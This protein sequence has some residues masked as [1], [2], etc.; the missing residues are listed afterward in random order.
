VA[1]EMVGK[2]N[3]GDWRQC[4]IVDRGAIGVRGLGQCGFWD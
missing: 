3:L 1:L 2:F 4:G